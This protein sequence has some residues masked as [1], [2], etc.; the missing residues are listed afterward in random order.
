MSLSL[1][2]DINPQKG[3]ILCMKGGIYS[4]EK[5]P[6]CGATYRGI[7]GDSLPVPC[8]RNAKQRGKRSF[9]GPSQNGLSHTMM[10][11]GF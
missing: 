2:Y 5:C 10:L 7:P 1:K 9:L 3:G 6:V 11:T 8:I 4:D